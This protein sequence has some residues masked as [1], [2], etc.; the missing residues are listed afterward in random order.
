MRKIFK[1]RQISKLQ[2]QISEEVNKNQKTHKNKPFLKFAPFD[3][4]I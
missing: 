1:N 3:L 2:P 4:T